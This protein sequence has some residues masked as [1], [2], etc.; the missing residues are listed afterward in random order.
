MITITHEDFRQYTGIDL[1]IELRD[2]DDASTKV[3]RTI[4]LWTLRVYREQRR[5]SIVPIP[6]DEK[7]KPNQVQ[8]IKDAICEYG[9]YY[10]KN[11]DLYR[12]S[13]F[14]EDKGVLIT[15]SDLDNIR[16]P[17]VCIDILRDA[18]LIRRSFGR[19]EYIGQDYDSFDY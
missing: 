3:E 14:N 6:D 1:E 4:K 10:F 2:L 19:R 7:L 16:F 11:G 8:A 18:G 13:G 15:K 12:Q 17:Q 5:N 9:E